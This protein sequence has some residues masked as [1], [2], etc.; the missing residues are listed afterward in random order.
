[1]DL[2]RRRL[3][4]SVRAEQAEDL[5]RTEL[6]LDALQRFELTVRLRQSVNAD[7]R[8]HE[9]ESSSVR[10]MKLDDACRRERRLDSVAELGRDLPAVRLMA[11]PHHGPAA[12]PDPPLPCGS[13]GA[14]PR[15]IAGPARPGDL[16]GNP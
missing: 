13:G 14:G 1:E 10:E 2:D 12:A 15:R 7:D 11:A 8:G 9:A 16:A 3:A 5:A 4:G 6:E